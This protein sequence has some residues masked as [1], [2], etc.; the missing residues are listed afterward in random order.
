MVGRHSPRS[1]LRSRRRWHRQQRRRHPVSVVKSARRVVRNVTAFSRTLGIRLRLQSTPPV[2]Y[3]WRKHPNFGDALNR[4]LVAAI[5]GRD[6]IHSQDVPGSYRGPVYAAIGSVLG[7][8]NISNLVVWGSGFISE[9]AAFRTP[10]VRICAV[11]GPLSRDRFIELGLSCPAVYGDPALLYPKFFATE[12]RPEHDLGIIPHYADAERD[13]V[14]RLVDDGAYLI[15]VEGDVHACVRNIRRC[16][17]IAS[18]SLHGVIIALS[19]GIPTV[20]VEFSDLVVGGGFKFR[21]FYTSIHAATPSPLRLVKGI[22]ATSLVDQA[23][24]T[25]IDLDL[26]KLL[27]ACPFARPALTR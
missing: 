7:G 16:R 14:R 18:S 6:P 23:V 26:D 24:A 22:R 19:F 13:M 8:I 2:V 3:W 17:T 11:R 4:P 15:D 9:T 20:W 5:S 12:I 27:A 21:D 1:V 25:P 10:P